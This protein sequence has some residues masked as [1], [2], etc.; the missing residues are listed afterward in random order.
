MSAVGVLFDLDGTLVDTAPDLVAVLNQ[1]LHESG[2]VRMPFAIA[3]NEV[4][5][6]DSRGVSVRTTGYSGSV[7]FQDVYIVGNHIDENHGDELWEDGRVGHVRDRHLDLLAR[8]RAQVDVPV[9]VASGVARCRVPRG[10]STPCRRLT[11]R[12]QPSDSGEP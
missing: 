3:R 12:S 11:R 1:L 4:S 6:N 8:E 9:L 2:R 5:N 7:V 10:C